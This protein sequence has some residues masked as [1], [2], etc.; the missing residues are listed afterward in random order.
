M[1]TGTITV[2]S[3]QW[4]V[5]IARTS[6]ELRAGLSNVE[7]LAADNGILFDMGSDQDSIPINMSEMLFNLDI[8]FIN[9]TGGVVGI[10]RG[11]VP[12]SSP[13]FE[14]GAGLGARFFL[15][16]NAGEAV[17]VEVGDG[18][19]I[20][21]DPAEGVT[22]PQLIGV[23][24]GAMGLAAVGAATGAIVTKAIRGRGK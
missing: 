23:V 11:V 10:V 7:V 17:D 22:S 19:S 6:S 3:K 4:A 2:G 9:S 15:E 1:I 21:G 20:E 14:A 5:Q 16:V 18:A 24:L 8:I 13:A 12:G